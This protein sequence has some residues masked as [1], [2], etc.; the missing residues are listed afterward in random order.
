LLS[1][2]SLVTSTPTTARLSVSTASCTFTAGR[3][4]PSGIFITRA[5][6]SVVLAVRIVV[7]TSVSF[8]P[9]MRR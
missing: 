1:D 2:P 8:R 3:K 7:I 5:S 6:A 9:N 4:P